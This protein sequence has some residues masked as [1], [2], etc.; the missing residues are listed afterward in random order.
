MDSLGSTLVQAP[1]IPTCYC[2]VSSI[3]SAKTDLANNPEK[4][5]SSETILAL[6]HEPDVPF[7]DCLLSL[8]PRNF[9]LLKEKN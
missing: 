8:M 1:L 3:V 9:T 4:P 2:K 7:L 6:D 5:L